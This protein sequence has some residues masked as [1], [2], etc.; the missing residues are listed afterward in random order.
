[1]DTKPITLTDGTKSLTFN[2]TAT[3]DTNALRKS[4]NTAFGAEVGSVLD[5][6]KVAYP[7]HSRALFDLATRENQDRH[8]VQFV[9]N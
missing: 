3:M 9:K 4:I 6:K 1:M 7:V 8:T 2:I 5:A